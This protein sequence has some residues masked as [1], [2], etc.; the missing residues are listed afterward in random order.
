MRIRA[1]QPGD[2]P[3][4]LAVNDEAFGGPAEGDLVEA[5][6]DG[7]HALVSLVAVDEERG[8]LVGHILFSRLPITTEAGT[9]Q[10]AALAPMAVRT[11]RQR[12]GV[13]SLLVRSGLEACRRLGVDVVVV[14]GHPAYYPRF[15]F[16][17]AAARG[18]ASPWSTPYGEHDAPPAGSEAFMML[19]LREGAHGLVVGT[20]HYAPPFTALVG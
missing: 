13:G 9:L 8:E 7:G 3:A 10:G 20:A 12:S 1:E 4:I 6:R 14:L 19:D 5:L 16:S 18:L 17:A 15:G 11:S 2:A